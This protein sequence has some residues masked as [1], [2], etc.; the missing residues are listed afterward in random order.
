MELFLVE[1]F[2]LEDLTIYKVDDNFVLKTIEH[3]KPNGYSQ[4]TPVCI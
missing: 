1:S 4:S 2:S 3:T